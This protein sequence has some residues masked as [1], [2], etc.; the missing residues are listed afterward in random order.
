MKLQP[1]RF[2][3]QSVNAYGDG[4]LALNGERLE[5]SV[6][7]GSRGER[8]AWQAVSS[9]RLTA[10]DFEPVAALRPE[11]VIFG[12][13]QALRFPPP[14]ALRPLIQASIG[15]ETMDSAAACRTYNILAGEG[16][17]V[18]GAILVA[19]AAEPDGDSHFG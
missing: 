6:V 11:V 15:I 2:D 19:S 9:E 18:V 14:A 12:S 4:W 1:D 7:F 16:R 10:A 8:F 17:H 13:G 3:V 5:H